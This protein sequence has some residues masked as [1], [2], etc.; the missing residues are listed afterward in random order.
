MKTTLI[1]GAS[2]GIGEVFARRMA[3]RGDNLVL[4]A[5][6]ADK[7]AALAD[8]LKRAHHIDAQ[9]IALDLAEPDAPARLFAETGR[10]G[11]EVETLVNNA[12]F[13]SVGELTSLEL[14]GQLKMIDL[15]VRSLMELT[16]LYLVPMR[17]RRRG[18]VINV[19]STAAFQPMP[20]MATYAATKAFVLSF[21][22][23]LSEE[24]RAHGIK[25]LAL[26]PGSTSTNFFAVA[27]AGT[28]P[29]Q[30]TQ[31]P[32]EVVETA[33]RALD[34]GQAVVI[35]GWINWLMVASERLAPRSLVAKIAGRLVSGR[36]KIENS[37]RGENNDRENL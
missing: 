36:H 35:S 32:E 16:Y 4:V 22:E 31:T 20:Y 17:E 12:G 15:N 10:R 6:S 9:H 30:V 27:G 24:N 26:C 28:P 11:L 3:A 1:T 14:E 7:L 19:A 37:E 5:R 23:A 8:E 18:A 34:K 21:S 13:G 25:M 33:L 29:P 2:G